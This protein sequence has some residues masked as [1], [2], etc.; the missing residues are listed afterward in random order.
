MVTVD[1]SVEQAWENYVVG[2][3]PFVRVR[4]S[5]ETESGEKRG[6]RRRSLTYWLT[7]EH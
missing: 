6:D 1:R 5:G 2:P 4:A 3:G 7:V